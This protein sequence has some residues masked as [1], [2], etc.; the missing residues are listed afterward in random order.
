MSDLTAFIGRRD[1]FGAMT[2]RAH[3]PHLADWQSRACLGQQ[4]AHKRA[5][6]IDFGDHRLG[7]PAPETCRHPRRPGSRRQRG[8]GILKNPDHPLAI[9][10]DNDDPGLA[11]TAK[12]RID[13]D[14]DTLQNTSRRRRGAAGGKP[15]TP[16]QRPGK[17]IDHLAA[18]FLACQR[19]VPVSRR[20]R[21][22]EPGRQIRRIL[23]RRAAHQNGI[24][25]RG[26]VTK[27]AA[28]PRRGGRKAARHPPTAQ[29]QHQIVPGRRVGPF[30]D[31]VCPGMIEFGAA[32]LFRVDRRITSRHRAVRPFQPA[33]RALPS[34]PAR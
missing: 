12:R 34:R 7:P 10:A 16:P 24:R 31:L 4:A 17:R 8:A 26:K 15:V 19:A 23:G 30:A 28:G 6:L 1:R 29:G 33:Q 11:G 5:A 3:G 27:P 13:T 18:Q 22:Q 9:L 14:D 20:H 2:F 25:R 21:G 32:K